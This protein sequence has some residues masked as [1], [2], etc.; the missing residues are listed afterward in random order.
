MTVAVRLLQIRWFICPLSKALEFEISFAGC[1]TRQS[2]IRPINSYS[3]RVRSYSLNCNRL[4]WSFGF[5][6]QDIEGLACKFI[7]T[8]SW[9]FARNSQV[10]SV[11][12]FSLFDIFLTKLHKNLQWLYRICSRNVTNSFEPLKSC[13]SNWEEFTSKVRA[14][15]FSSKFFS[16]ILI[17]QVRASSF[18]SKFL[19]RELVSRF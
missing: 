14:S 8:E 18:R 4:S 1:E 7:K 12:R 17:S 9:K 13:W 6:D 11:C 15:F 16:K 2:Q 3:F 19:L 10:A 5:G